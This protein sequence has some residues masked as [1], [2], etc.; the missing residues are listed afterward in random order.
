METLRLALTTKLA[1]AITA[2]C[3]DS[4]LVLEMQRMLLQLASGAELQGP[5]L[6]EVDA[7][8]RSLRRKCQPEWSR[9]IDIIDTS[10]LTA[11]PEQVRAG[12]INQC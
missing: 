8:L 12:L 7:L 3:H 5:F 1:C 2:G 9:T 4:D 10:V 11:P 6:E